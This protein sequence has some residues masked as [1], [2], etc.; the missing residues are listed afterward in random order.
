[1]L[2]VLKEIREKGIKLTINNFIV[3][4]ILVP[5][6]I[7]WRCSLNDR[8]N[9]ISSTSL[10]I[11][12]FICDISIGYVY[13]LSLASRGRK[14]N[15]WPLDIAHLV[16]KIQFVIMGDH[17][18]TCKCTE[19]YSRKTGI[20]STNRGL[21][22]LKYAE[23]KPGLKKRHV[24]CNNNCSTWLYVSVKETHCIINCEPQIQLLHIVEK[25]TILF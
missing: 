24:I 11:R 14:V 13:C 7:S 21:V 3:K 22:P 1:M 18:M 20:R 19:N 15:E 6:T 16:Q 10:K 4:S 2:S 25:T 8:L 17:A 5:A 23:W 12:M 9:S